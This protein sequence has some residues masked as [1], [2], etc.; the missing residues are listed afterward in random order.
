MSEREKKYELKEL[1]VTRNHCMLCG[2][3]GSEYS[4]SDTVSMLFAWEAVGKE[5]APKEL[6]SVCVK[7]IDDGKWNLVREWLEEHG[8]VVSYYTLDQQ[9]H[10]P[11]TWKHRDYD[12][13]DRRLKKD[14]WG[15]ALDRLVHEREEESGWKLERNLDKIAR[16]LGVLAGKLPE[17]F[18]FRSDTLELISTTSVAIEVY[19]EGNLV[20][21]RAGNHTSHFRRGEWEDMIPALV[22]EANERYVEQRREE[23]Y[24]EQREQMDAFGLSDEDIEREI[25]SAGD[26]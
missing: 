16:H 3:G 4:A 13:E 24:Q 11:I 9:M 22:A 8:G 12:L 10:H 7:C 5:R 21:R 25:Q 20:Y 1:G 6:I 17:T 2:L 14:E 18:E 19:Y 26:E 23:I 15:W